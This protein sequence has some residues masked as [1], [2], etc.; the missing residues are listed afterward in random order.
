MSKSL[1]AF[2]LHNLVK[3]NV[4]K[5]RRPRVFGALERL[6]LITKTSRDTYIIPADIAVARTDIP[7]I[8]QKV[9]ECTR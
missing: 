4:P 7:E 9:I 5:S 6:G 1:T 8:S 2:Q 3:A